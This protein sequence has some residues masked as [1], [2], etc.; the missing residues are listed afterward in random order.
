MYIEVGRSIRPT[1]PRP[2]ETIMAKTTKKNAKTTRKN[3]RVAKPKQTSKKSDLN[4]AEVMLTVAYPKARIVKGS[5]RLETKGKYANKRSVLVTCCKR[6]CTK[7]R[8][9]AS[10]D[11]WQS[12]PEGWYCDS[13]C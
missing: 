11:L 13:H 10:S 12:C 1:T 3:A 4:A 7:Q 5:L 9:F 6:G 2:G 8:R